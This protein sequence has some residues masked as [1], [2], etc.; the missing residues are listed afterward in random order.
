[1]SQ[2]YP[3]GLINRSAPVVV[4]PTG[5]P[6][7]GGSAP[8]IWT[9]EQ[10]AG[11]IKQG[12]WPRPPIPR[13]LF[14]WGANTNGEL[15]QNNL[16]DRSSPV[17]VGTLS[18]W[19]RLS[20]ASNFCAAI[21][22][23]GTLWSWGSNGQGQ[24]G[25]NDVY[26]RR[27]SPTQVGALTDWSQVTAG[28]S[29]CAAIKL[30]GTLWS[31]GQNSGGILGQNIAYS[32]RRSSPVQVGALTDWAQ[33]GAGNSFCASIKTNGTLWSWGA[34]SYGQLGQNISYAINRSSPVQIGALTDWARVSAGPN[35]CAAIK[36]DGTLWTWGNNSSGQL[37]LNSSGYTNRSSP[38]QVG[39]LTDWAQVSAGSSFCTAIKTN[40]TLWSWGYNNNGQLGINNVSG[41]GR[42]SPVQVGALTDWSQVSAAGNFCVAIKTTGTL[43][44]WGRNAD[45]RLGL[46]DE[47]N[48]SS[49]VQVGA[50][51]TW[52]RLWQGPSTSFSLAIK[53]S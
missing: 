15:G 23:N 39:A 27:S 25:L 8:G 48:R 29:T 11:Y 22:T 47:N 9:L 44:S 45:G 36:S 28:G 19:A 2:R 21:K 32:I 17:Q 20:A 14:S 52:T 33:I 53:T 13:Q 35:F 51:T 6:P 5:S 38:T 10:A 37:G 42:S 41:Y 3:G 18:D 7:E 12:L 4:G 43:W 49:P 30:N 24:L 50:L 40:G 34:G 46:N 1:M 26:I 31:W 16:I